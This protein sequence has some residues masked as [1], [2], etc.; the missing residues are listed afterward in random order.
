MSATPPITAS[1][2][3]K[4][5]VSRT[6]PQAASID[7]QYLGSIDASGA[8]TVA[9][10]NAHWGFVRAAARRGEPFDVSA[11]VRGFDADVVVVPESFRFADGTTVLD[12][13]AADGYEIQSRKF[14]WLGTHN[15]HQ[16]NPPVDGHWELA[17][18]SRLAV[19]EWREI[20]MARVFRDHVDEI[21]R[22]IV[23]IVD[24]DGVGVPIVGLHTSSKL[25]YAGPVMH[26]RSLRSALP[27]LSTP[28]VIAGDHNLWG[29]GVCALLPGWRRAVRGRTWPGHRPHSQL[30]HI[31]VSKR[32][33]VLAGE[34]LAENGSD[35]RPVRARLA[36]R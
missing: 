21:R 9:A 33:E 13:I 7:P 28:A 23:A 3:R 20:Q 18:C 22:A 14:S 4:G 34:V 16:D 15:R 29:P 11:L 2:S 17:V 8:F 12:G 31:L 30:D 26:L 10:F 6:D 32:I 35:H 36:L 5:S 19:R 24:V 27:D 1:F 25:W